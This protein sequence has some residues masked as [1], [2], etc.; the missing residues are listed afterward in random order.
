LVA[1]GALVVVASIMLLVF[2]DQI[3]GASTPATPDPMTTAGP[4]TSSVSI[5]E[6]RACEAQKEKEKRQRELE[7]IVKAG[8][9]AIKERNWA[10]ARDRFEAVLEMDPL[11]DSA[12]QA[13]NR[14]IG[15]QADKERLE[16]ARTLRDGLKRGEAAKRL[17]E[18]TDTSVYFAEA[19]DGLRE[20]MASK[21]TVELKAQNLLANKD[22]AG[23]IA[24]LRQIQAI[25]PIDPAPGIKIEEI[26]KLLNN[27]QRCNSP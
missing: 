15:W 6:D 19:Q 23:A 9:D 4:V 13:V 27:K 24:E 7:A 3:F 11:N 1:I 22:C 16:E 12:R 21:S 18:I 25:D 8:N 17:R 2:K 26:Q 10:Y 14:I 5:A 20:L